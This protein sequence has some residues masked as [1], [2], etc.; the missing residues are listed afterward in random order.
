MKQV[1]ATANG[2]VQL[3]DLEVMFLE[4]KLLPGEPARAARY[5]GGKSCTGTKAH[6]AISTPRFGRARDSVAASNKTVRRS[7]TLRSTSQLEMVPQPF[8]RDPR[9]SDGKEDYGAAGAVGEVSQ[10]SAWRG[11]SANPAA[12]SRIRC[13][14]RAD[15][16]VLARPSTKTTGPSELI[17]SPARRTGTWRRGP[18]SPSPRVAPGARP[19]SSG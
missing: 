13:A 10:P 9:R 7:G 3:R 6:G 16:C 12:A 4:G 15:P 14:Y 17:A 8:R 19:R 11:A 2:D 18:G 5:P 1:D